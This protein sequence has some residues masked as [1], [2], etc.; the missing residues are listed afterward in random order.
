MR[1]G[2][3]WAGEQKGEE[4]DIPLC[5]FEWEGGCR[6]VDSVTRNGGNARERACRHLTHLY[7]CNPLTD[8]RGPLPRNRDESDPCPPRYEGLGQ[9]RAAAQSGITHGGLHGAQ[10]E[11]RAAGG[12]GSRRAGRAC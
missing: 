3:Q 2:I 6:W 5:W 7:S 4:T 9:V 1:T 12:K 10:A 11:G 8:C